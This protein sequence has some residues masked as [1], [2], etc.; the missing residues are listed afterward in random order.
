MARF[1]W[2]GA[3]IHEMENRGMIW[4][5]VTRLGYFLTKFPL[6]ATIHN[7]YLEKIAARLVKIVTRFWAAV[8]SI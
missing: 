7:G 6:K 2:P 8:T 4:E 5:I 1:C 3:R